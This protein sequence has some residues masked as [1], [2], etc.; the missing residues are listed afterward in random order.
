VF[1]ALKQGKFKFLYFLSDPFYKFKKNFILFEI[2]PKVRV[3]REQFTFHWRKSAQLQN[4]ILNHSIFT[5]R[6][7]KWEF[8]CSVV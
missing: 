8:I 4:E 5:K 2:M 1:F 7:R 3:F 6:K